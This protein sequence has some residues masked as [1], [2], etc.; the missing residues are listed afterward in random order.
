MAGIRVY[1][2]SNFSGTSAYWAHTA[3]Y[4]YQRIWKS[5]LSSANLHDNISSLR[6][7]AGAGDLETAILFE[8]AHF[9]GRF[10][11]FRGSDPRRDVSSLGGSLNFHDRTSSILLVA[12]DGSEF[13]PL[14]LGELARKDATDGIDD[15]LSGVSEASRRGSI[16]FT[17]EMWPDFDPTKKFVRVDVP[18]RVH[19]PVWSDYDARA[20][21]YIYLYIDGS[22]RLRGYVSWVETWVE[23]GILAGSINSRLHPEVANAAGQ[24]NN[25]LNDALTELDFHEWSRYYLM[26]GVGPIVPDDYHGNVKDDVTV[27][28]VRREQ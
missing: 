8:H 18:L 1:R 15:A 22:H 19:V 3:G 20:T 23:A 2:H 25:L 12:H 27:M 9:K 28:L 6:V 5:T 16:V 7:Y 13:L 26:P 11:A 4:R 10:V 24:V 21:Y 14:H 17:W